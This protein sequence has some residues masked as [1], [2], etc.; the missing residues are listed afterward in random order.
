MELSKEVD[1]DNSNSVKRLK[2]NVNGF[3]TQE[4]VSIQSWKNY[5]HMNSVE[6]LIQSSGSRL[7]PLPVNVP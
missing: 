6:I 7:N 4:K 3:L 1:Q 5:N 2:M